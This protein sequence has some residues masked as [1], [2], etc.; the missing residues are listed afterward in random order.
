MLTNHSHLVCQDRREK[1]EIR[2]YVYVTNYSLPSHI[3][4]WNA[5]DRSLICQTTLSQFV[6]P[7]E[8][9]TEK[10]AALLPAGEQ[11]FSQKALL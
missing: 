4:I 11:F 9:P 3:Y 10:K 5:I 7:R 1:R 2:E 6:K 8:E